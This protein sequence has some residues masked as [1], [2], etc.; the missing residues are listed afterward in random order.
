MSWSVYAMGKARL[1]EEKCAET[2]AASKCVE[3]EETIKAKIAESL[4]AAMG[5]FPDDQ[6]VKV[7][8]NGHQSS[9]GPDGKAINQF[10]VK[11]E[12][13]YGFLE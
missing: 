4:A 3:P 10:S 8:A 7:E 11:V 6:I 13:V 2:L 12:P 1:V 5:A 9:V